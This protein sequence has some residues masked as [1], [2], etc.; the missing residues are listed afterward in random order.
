LVFSWYFTNR[1]QRKT[2]LVHFGIKKLAGAP[3][4]L[5]KGG[6]WTHFGALSPPFEEKRVTHGFFQKNV[7]RNF[8]KEFPPNPTEQ[9]CKPDIPTG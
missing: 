5:Q 4:S 1:H 9:K 7:P 3:F 2:W 8:K 6:L